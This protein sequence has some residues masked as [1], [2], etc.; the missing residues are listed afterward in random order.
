MSDLRETVSIDVEVAGKA[1]ASKELEVQDASTTSGPAEHPKPRKRGRPRKDYLNEIGAIY[2]DEKILHVYKSPKNSKNGPIVKAQ[3]IKWDPINKR[4]CGAITKPRLRDL[5][6]GHTKACT[7][8]LRA[9][10]YKKNCKT[11]LAQLSNAM[12]AD[13]W[14]AAPFGGK[15]NREAVAKKFQLPIVGVIDF[16]AR[17]YEEHLNSLVKNEFG[18]QLLRQAELH[19][20][21]V[22]GAA[23]ANGLSVKAARYIIGAVKR[24]TK[25]RREALEDIASYAEWA[26][27]KVKE[28]ETGFGSGLWRNEFTPDELRKSKGKV[29]GQYASL[30]YDC[31]AAQEAGLPADQAKHIQAFLD[32]AGFTFDERTDRKEAKLRQIRREEEREGS[33]AE[34]MEKLAA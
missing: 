5:R 7:R 3:C 6:S 17:E 8:C 15:K 9:E 29:V 18:V 16:A 21:G 26:V 19:E 12:I 2:G 31:I 23:K 28:R 30:Y 34:L 14:E 24:N 20:G 1:G 10:V 27:T 22:E 33:R 4:T 13:I 25:S 32:L 11:V